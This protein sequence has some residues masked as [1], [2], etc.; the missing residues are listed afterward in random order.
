MEFHGMSWNSEFHRIPWDSIDFHRIPWNSLES[1]ESN[2][3]PG[4]G[5]C[6]GPLRSALGSSPRTSLSL[7][8]PQDPLGRFWGDNRGVCDPFAK[9]HDRDTTRRLRG[10][11]SDDWRR[12]QR[13]ATKTTIGDCETTKTTIGGCEYGPPAEDNICIVIIALRK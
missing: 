3:I 5:E 8:S 4:L 1:M 13:L 11:E 6:P 2:G 10:D 12:K 9:R 7:D